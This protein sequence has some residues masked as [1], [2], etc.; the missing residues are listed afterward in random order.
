MNLRNPKDIFLHNP[1]RIYCFADSTVLCR[2]LLEAGARV[3]QL[4]HKTAD[5]AA[6]RQIAAEMLALV[7]SFEDAVLIVNDRV[8]I[9]LEMGADGVHVGQEDR[10]CREV[11]NRAP[12]SMIVGVSAR[13]A[14]LARAAGRAGA[15]YVGAGAVFAT[16]TKSE[17]DVIGLPGLRE[18]VAAV[19]IPVVAIGGIAAANLRTVLAAGVRYCA[20]ISGI[21]DAP[22]PGAALQQLL[23]TSA[24]FPVRQGR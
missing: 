15:T 11:V 1:G 5:D 22:D 24:S 23:A 20:V 21:N 16:S 8:D 9:A 17:A 6:F 19:D 18:V 10:D 3:I 4:R 12:A 2:T 14:V 7:R 13:T